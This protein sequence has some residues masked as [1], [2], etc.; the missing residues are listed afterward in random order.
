MRALSFVYIILIK[1]IFLKIFTF[2]QKLEQ[3]MCK[4]LKKIN[5]LI[6]NIDNIVT[7]KINLK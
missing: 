4:F 5:I 1:Q 2:Y 7:P 6:A 3:K